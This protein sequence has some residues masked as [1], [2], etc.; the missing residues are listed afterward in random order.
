[1]TFFLLG[2]IAEVI[3]EMALE[4]GMIAE[5]MPGPRV[6]LYSGVM[7]ISLILVMYLMLRVVNL[8]H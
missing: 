2:G 3:F 8:M 5:R 4:R 7:A 1:M 6:F